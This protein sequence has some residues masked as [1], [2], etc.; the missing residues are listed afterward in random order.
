MAQKDVVLDFLQQHPCIF[1]DDCL[2]RETKIEPR[3]TIF[4]LCTALYNQELIERDKLECS[5]CGKIKKASRAKTI[6]STQLPKPLTDTTSKEVKPK[7]KQPRKAY[8]DRPT[9]PDRFVKVPLEFEKFDIENVFTQFDS[10][11]LDEVLK[12]E[13][14]SKFHDPVY[15]HY[16]GYLSMRLGEFLGMLKDQGDNF[17]KQF[18]NAYGDQ[19]F[20]KFRM[21]DNPFLDRKGLYLFKSENQIKYVG[22][23]KGDLNF[24]LRINTGYAYISPKNCYI[25]VSQRTAISMQ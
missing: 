20:C 11:T 23:V 9:N 18:L 2:S 19:S 15:A 3:Q 8:I 6:N 1:C 10:Y 17:Y 7:S 25:V 22:R 14:Y 24:H 12:K 16:S 5:V 13:K 4:Q 21:A